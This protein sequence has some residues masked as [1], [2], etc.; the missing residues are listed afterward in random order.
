MLYRRGAIWWYEFVICGQRI[1][2]STHSRSRSVARRAMERRRRSLEE[3]I[4]GLS[5]RPRPIVFHAAASE[6]LALKESKWTAST[7]RIESKNIEHLC[8]T[9]RHMVLF[10]ITAADVSRYQQRRA[11]DGA[12]GA[13][14][15]LEVAT[16]RAILRRYR[17]WAAL[18]P[19]VEAMPTRDDVGKALTVTEEERL[20]YACLASRSRML[21]PAVA[22]TLNTGLR[23]GELLS[24][25]WSQVDL[26]GRWLKI[27]A[28]KTF[29]GRG[30]LVPLN[31][32]AAAALSAWA[33]QFPRY[34]PEHAVFPTERVGARGDDFRA[35][36]THSDPDT[37]I[38]SLQTA[39]V[40][41]KKAA[42]VS[43]RWHDLRHTVCT[44]LL[45]AGLSLPL[46]GRILGWSASTMV[47][48]THRY[49]H[50]DALTQREAM[51]RLDRL[52]PQKP[53]QARR[54]WTT[55][56][57]RFHSEIPLLPTMFLSPALKRVPTN[58]HTI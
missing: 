4:N 19:D 10:D 5:K 22:V 40:S 3:G 16:L 44:R 2:E 34:K 23:R 27:G 49:G 42:G 51:A 52:T 35:C 32:A 20:L 48:M 50:V 25:R 8:S 29:A 28:S 36:I 21:Y 14:I 15:N 55:T 6:H 56:N 45:E 18:Q 37:P 47:V 30:R 41:A 58:L 12:S 33:S 26:A 13:T 31:A 54:S 7:R 57:S 43:L 1:R 24:L 9:F 53:P 38:R 17:L 39:W 11:Q 46:V